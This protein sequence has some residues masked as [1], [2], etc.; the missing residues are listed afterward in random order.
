MTPQRVYVIDE[1][2]PPETRR[3]STGATAG[4]PAGRPDRSNDTS[5]RVE[6]SCVLALRAYALGPLNLTLWPSGRA[7]VAWATVGALSTIATASLCIWWRPFAE[8]ARRNEGSA[9]IWALSVT[10]VILLTAIAWARAV[11]TSDPGGHWP[12]FLRTPVT[13]C[14]LGFLFPGFGLLIARRRRRSAVAIWFAGVLVAAIV[15]ATRWLRL[16]PALVGESDGG[17]H[18][19]FEVTLIAA[20]AGVALGALAWL[21]QALEGLRVVRPAARSGSL[22]N[23]LA[24]ALLIAVALFLA[25]FHPTAVARDFES[26]ALQFRQ[27][28]LRVIPLALYESAAKL[29]P[30]TPAYLAGAA[31]LHDDIGNSKTAEMRSA[32]L[33][34]RAAQFADALGADLVPAD[35]RTTTSWSTP[36]LDGFDP[37]PSRVGPRQIDGSARRHLIEWPPHHDD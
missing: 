13:V 24:L 8:V 16:A 35:S 29:D 21:V 17:A 15:I 36:P 19:T 3:P 32:L 10:C 6:G 26:A 30:A 20:L 12:R 4:R 34:E 18:W 25:T 27:R 1:P 31:A 11:A 14:A 37:V 9:V 22:A 23:G 33:R 28:G 5:R 2:K 7:R